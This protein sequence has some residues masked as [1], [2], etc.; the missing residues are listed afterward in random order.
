MARRFIVTLLL[1]SGLAGSY[2]SLSA[3]PP[4]RAF[5]SAEGFGAFTSGG[6][7][8][9]ALKVTNLNDAGP[10]SLRAAIDAR[11]PRIVIFETGGTI[12]LQSALKIRNSNITIAG[13]TAPGD[14][15]ALGGHELVVEASEVIIRYLR[16]RVGDVNRVEADA[17]SVAAGQNIII[18]HCSASWSTDETF[19]VAQ[20]MTLGEKQLNNVTVQW[21]IISESLDQSVHSKGAHGYGSLVRGSAGSRYSFHH[22]LW[23]HHRARMPRPGN[24][25]D[26][27]TDPVGPTV[28][29]TN[30]VF[31]NW[32]GGRNDGSGYNADTNAI[33]RYNFRGNS[34]RTGANSL[35]ALA[36]VESST[37][38]RAHFAGNAMN[39]QLVPTDT[40]VRLK[41]PV[42]DYFSLT[43]FENANLAPAN[44]LIAEQEVLARAGAS[45]RR[46]SADAR[47]VAGVRT[48]TGQ[49]I[50][51]QTDVGGWPVLAAGTPRID[52][53][54]DGMPDMWERRNRLNP[55]NPVDGTRDANRD[56]V[57]NVEEWLNSL[58]R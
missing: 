18:D 5:P 25:A 38:A 45:L 24:F 37:G 15:I 35:S 52:T 48:R 12:M 29:F 22:N 8:G 57:T 3:A 4:V 33:S 27:V 19:S 20:Q 43:P 10:G 42:G 17:I 14:G 21:S 32:G 16:V 7:G 26:A 44:A 50:N 30:N 41:R 23:A 54:G 58:A 55:S 6:R 13:Q 47:V 28:D 46:D 53:D 34:Y 39:G 36:F 40:I 31:Y 56:G 2:G 9:R 11:G 1:T 51:S 49:I